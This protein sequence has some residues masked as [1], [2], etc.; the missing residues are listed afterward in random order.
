MKKILFLLTL[1]VIMV[2]AGY[3]LLLKP[4][5]EI[6][7]AVAPKIEIIQEEEQG[8]VMKQEILSNVAQC[9]LIKGAYETVDGDFHYVSKFTAAGEV[10]AQGY[11]ISG[12]EVIWGESVE[13]IYL[14]ISPIAGET[15]STVFY[16]YYSSVIDEGN[17][18]NAKDGNDLLFKLGV[19]KDGGLFSTANISE[20][21]KPKII[22]SINKANKLS[23]LIKVP[24]FN[25]GGA[26]AHF[27][28][29]CSIVLSN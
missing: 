22:S 3:I 20:L 15:P 1:T 29:A 18:I 13:S 8:E 2:I 11:I 21:A 7:K 6:K 28:P 25:G 9:N 10:I 19:F 23:L 4:R 26:P 16:S 5:I 27:T 12:K 24:I 14:K 17:T